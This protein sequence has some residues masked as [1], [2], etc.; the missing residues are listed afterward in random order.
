MGSNNHKERIYP[1]SFK[2][3]VVEEKLHSGLGFRA[4]GR[5]YNVPHNLV[6]ILVKKYAEHGVESLYVDNRGAPGEN[7]VKGSQLNSS[8][9]KMLL[10]EDLRQSWSS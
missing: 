3:T 5:K 9:L 10:C 8:N 7:E 6:M 4:I 1:G 2:Q